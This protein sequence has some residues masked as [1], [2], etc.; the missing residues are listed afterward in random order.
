MQYYYLFRNFYDV[1]KNNFN[2]LKNIADLKIDAI[3]KQ[4]YIYEQ[5]ST[6][7]NIN[8]NE[9]KIDNKYFFSKNY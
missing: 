5:K 9:I 1:K 8:N 2:L 4:F 6:E 3:D 7:N